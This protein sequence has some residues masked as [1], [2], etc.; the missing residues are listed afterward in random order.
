MENH[1][2]MNAVY[3]H[4]YAS[5]ILELFDDVLSLYG[6]K[7]PSPEDYERESDNMVGLYGSTYSDLLDS[8]EDRIIELID[9]YKR[10]QHVVSYEY[11]GSY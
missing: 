8:V 5:G 6:I 11:S 9:E 4:D 1:T 10:K 3:T 2:E 7:V